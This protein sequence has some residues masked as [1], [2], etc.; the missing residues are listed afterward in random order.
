[1]TIDAAVRKFLDNTFVAPGVARRDELVKYREERNRHVGRAQDVEGRLTTGVDP[2]DPRRETLRALR[3]EL[4]LR[5]ESAELADVIAI[6]SPCA[7]EG[8][9]LLAAE[10]AITFAQTGH[11]TLLVD[12]DLRRPQQH[13]QFGLMAGNGLTQAISNEEEPQLC[14]VKGLPRMSLLPAGLL[15]SDPL[16]LLSSRRFADLIESWRDSFEFVLIDTAPVGAYSDGIAVANLT[17]RVL[18]LSRAQH[19]PAREM[20]NMLQRLSA[21][22]SQILGAVVNHF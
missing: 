16:E 6:L 21:A 4:L 11:T 20:Q 14:T 3:T 18:A 7:G 19:T 9:S 13:V 17:G 2:V 12:A 10:L 5:R 15:P 1:M 8:R 22:R